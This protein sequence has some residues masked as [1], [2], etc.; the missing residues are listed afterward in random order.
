MTKRIYNPD[1]P[2]RKR[3]FTPFRPSVMGAAYAAEQMFDFDPLEESSGAEED[4][5]SLQEEPRKLTLVPVPPE[6]PPSTVQEAPS[7]PQETPLWI[8]QV[9]SVDLFEVAE[10]LGLEVGKNRILPCPC[11]GDSRGAE[12]YKNQGGWIVWRCQQCSVRNRGNV[13][14]ASYVLAGE[15]AGDLPPEHQALLR[16]WFADQGWCESEE[17][18]E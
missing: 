4:T 1:P 3:G 2:R 6:P 8:Q 15:K 16:Q 9:R 10:V 13:D 14:L 12:V 11:C 7:R 5:R 18:H 17:N